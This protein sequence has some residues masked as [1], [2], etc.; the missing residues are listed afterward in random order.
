MATVFIVD[1]H[2]IVPMAI[3]LALRGAEDLSLQ[4]SSCNADDALPLIREARPDALI[5]DLVFGRQP[6]VGLISRCRDLLPQAVIVVFTSL[7]E[8]DWP[9]QALSAGSN[10]VIC[11]D[12]EVTVVIS[13]LR[14]LLLQR[15]H[16]LGRKGLA[17]TAMDHMRLTRREAEVASKLSLGASIH[18]IA[19]DLNISSKTAAVHRDNLRTKMQCASTRELIARLAMMLPS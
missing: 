12:Q 1:D 6:E 19:H 8:N 2:P 18:A 17:T 11:K 3:R 9:A 10:E 7:I 5:L 4:G 15:G 16:V 13:R 14:E